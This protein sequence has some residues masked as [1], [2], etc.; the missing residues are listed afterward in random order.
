MNRPTFCRESGEPVALPSR[1]IA[2]AS[3]AGT[4]KTAIPRR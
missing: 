2:P 3:R 4:L 1:V